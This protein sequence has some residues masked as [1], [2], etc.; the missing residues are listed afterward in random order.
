[1][2]LSS[3]FFSYV[4]KLKYTDVSKESVAFIFKEHL[5]NGNIVLIFVQL[6]KEVP[7]I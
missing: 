5:K 1:V 2:S 3:G 7:F 6:A 4:I